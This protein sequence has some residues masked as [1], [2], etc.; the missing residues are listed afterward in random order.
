MDLLT[1][2]VGFTASMIELAVWW[3]QAVKVWRSRRDPVGLAGVSVPTQCILLCATSCWGLYAVLTGSLWVGVPT[4]V[5][6]P[7][8]VVTITILRRARRLRR[9]K[10]PQNLRGFDDPLVD[11]TGAMEGEPARA[12][13]GC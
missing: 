8:A 11:V 5:N 9:P 3:P 13:H 1:Q 2:A 10:R 4:L 6:A 12:G 7:L